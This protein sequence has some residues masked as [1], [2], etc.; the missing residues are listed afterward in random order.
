MS[1]TLFIRVKMK[2]KSNSMCVD[3]F[4]YFDQFRHE[5]SLYLRSLREQPLPSKS[6]SKSK[7]QL[8]KPMECF[9]RLLEMKPPSNDNVLTSFVTF[10]IDERVQMTLPSL[11][12]SFKFIGGRCLH[13]FPYSTNIIP[14]DFRL[15]P[16]LRRYREGNDLTT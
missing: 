4:C 6:A 8:Q 3:G 10:G 11:T 15:F 5:T 1:R 16:P 2:C 7:N 14:Y 13:T 12:R 9:R